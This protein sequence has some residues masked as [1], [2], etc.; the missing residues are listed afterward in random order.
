MRGP[1]SLDFFAAAIRASSCAIFWLKKRG[2]LPGLT[3]SN[4]L[5]SRDESLHCD[6]ATH[7]YTEHVKN[8][9]TDARAHAIVGEAVAAEEA[10]V[11]ESLRSDIIGLSKDRM[12]KYVHHVANRLLVALGH[13]TLF[14]DAQ[15]LAFMDA[16]SIDSSPNFFEKRPEN[17]AKR[18]ATAG[19][20]ALDE[21]F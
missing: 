5:I 21:E 17:Y 20:I 13:P 11:R 12:V 19:E 8:R 16:I 6:F 1:G 10:F 4:E 15:S 18:S 9:L 2:I 14:D 7:L 3:F